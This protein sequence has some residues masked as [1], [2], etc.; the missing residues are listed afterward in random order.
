MSNSLK[1]LI[2]NLVGTIVNA[3]IWINVECNIGIVSACLPI[4][5]PIFSFCFGESLR[6]RIS[7]SRSSQNKGSQKFSEQKSGS[8][9]ST[10]GN[11]NNGQN[12]QSYRPERRKVRGWFS[13]TVSTL[14]HDEE[15]PRASDEEE[16]VPIGKIGV[17]RDLGLREDHELH[18]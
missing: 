13:G 1:L 4:M 5:R 8:N 18:R 14:T 17:E 16:M 9:I 3:G 12:L 11:T 7:R 10:P 2:E 6:S 15:R